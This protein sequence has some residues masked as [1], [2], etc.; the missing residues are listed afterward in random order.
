MSAPLV[1]N[2]RDGVCWTRRMVTSGGIALYAPESVRTCPEFVM[3]TLPELAEHGVV[4]SADVLPVPVGPESQAPL[5]DDRAKA[6][7][8][9]GEDG[10]PLLPMGAHWTDVPELVDRTLTGIRARLD[11]AQP[12]RW[13][14]SPNAEVPNTVCTQYD[15]YTRTV[16]RFVNVLSAD[17]ELVLHAHEDLAWCLGLIAKLRARVAELEKKADTARTEAIADT[18]DWLDEVGEKSA[19]H[20]VYT[21]DIPAARDMKRVAPLEDPHDSPL[22]HDYRLGRD[23]PEVTP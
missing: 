2:T 10:R 11:Q 13:F 5:E 16:G 8:G 9:R 7:W 23:L 19:A 21:C 15:G 17:L 20:L 6:P 12:G 18:G 3:A 4:G 14:V 22:H 1:V